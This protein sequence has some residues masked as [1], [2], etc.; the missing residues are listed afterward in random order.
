MIWQREHEMMFPPPWNSM[1]HMD[2][3]QLSATVATQ[4]T[5]YM[6]HREEINALHRQCGIYTKSAVVRQILDAVGWMDKFDLSHFRLLEPTAGDGAF[7]SEAAR[8]LVISCRKRGFAPKFS[9]IKD[10]IRAF[11]IHPRE[12]RKARVK[13]AKTLRALGV[14]QATSTALAREWISGVDFLLTAKSTPGFTHAVGNPPYVRWAKVPKSLRAR[15]SER[16]P[17]EMIGGD[18]FIPIL[19][20]ALEQ[21]RSQGKCGFL[22]SDRWRFMGFAQKFRMKWLPQLEIK[23]E[24][25]LLAVDAYVRDVDA[26][27]SILIACRT[28]KT[29]GSV[30]APFVQTSKTLKDYGFQVR[31]GP[32]LGHTA[33]FVLDEDENDVETNLLRPWIDASEIIDGQIVWRKR[34]VIAMHDDDGRLIDPWK[35]PR[36]LQRLERFKRELRKRSIVQNGALW[37]RPID[38]ICSRDWARP[39]LLIPEIAKVPRV[40][41][42][43]SGAIPSHGVYAVFA[44]DGKIDIVYEQLI[45]G[46]LARALDGLAPKI[47]GGYV[48]CYKRFLEQI[49]LR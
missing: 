46:G 7:V 22:C 24:D 29:E 45:G 17:R 16:L 32:A 13:V 1:P 11:E 8:R 42:D 31:V 9:K 19:D 36:A 34:H 25:S 48:R 4:S 2:H 37:F 3:R 43:L 35:F 39:K 33:A 30:A 21:V 44:Q 12:A 27:P 40:A 15:Y 41:L 5:A 10:C 38:R 23:S 26:Y 20:R 49:V 6:T 18:L 47:K 28:H 14:H